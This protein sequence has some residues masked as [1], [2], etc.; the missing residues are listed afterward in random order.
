MAAAAAAA[1]ERER[2]MSRFLFNKHHLKCR[3]RVSDDI[4]VK[5]VTRLGLGG[6]SNGIIAPPVFFETGDP[7]SLF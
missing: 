1:A 4:A 5:W 7:N 6:L 2:E 3:G